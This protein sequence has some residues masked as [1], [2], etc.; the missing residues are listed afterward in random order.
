MVFAVALGTLGASSLCAQSI[1][2][3]RHEFVAPPNDAKPMVRW[4]WFGPAVTKEEIARE[5]QQMHEG[6]FGG[7]EL[8]SVY[9]LA[10]DDPQKGVRNLPYGSPEMVEM[11][12]Y[13]QQQGRALGMRAD[14]TLGSGWPF[15]G[16]HISIDQAA[17]KLKIVVAELPINKL[18]ELQEGDVPVAAF[19]ANGTREHYDAATARQIPFP[20]DGRLLSQKKSTEPQVALFFISSHT[21]QMV[22]RAAVGGEGFVLDHM[23]RAAIDTHLLTVGESLLRGFSDAPPY[24]I[25]SDSLEVYGSDWTRDLPEEFK[26]RR[27]YDLI[28]HLPELAEGGTEQAEAV[29]HDWAVTLSDLVRE[30]YLKPMADFA[31]AHGTRFRSQ[32]Y[33]T[34]AVTLSDERIPQLPEGEGPQW[35]SFSF[36][37][38]ASSANHLFG[39]NVTSAETWTWLHSP[40]FRATPLD[41]KAEADRMFLEGVNQ[42]IG[43]GWPYSPPYATEP[44]YSLYAAAVFNAH[45]PWWPVMP[46]VTR[47]LQRVSW[48]LRQGQP[49]NDVAV[50]LPEDDAQAD[51]RPGHVSV[52]DEM[53]VKITPT[54][55]HAIL[56]SGHNLDYVDGPAL[57]GL[58]GHSLLIVPPA[59][60]IRLQDLQQ[61]HAYVRGGGKVIF[62]GAVP[63]MAPGLTDAN[64]T[65]KIHALMTELQAGTVHVEGEEELSAAIERL[66]RPDLDVRSANGAVGFIRRHLPGAEIYFIANTSAETKTFPLRSS[67]GYSTAEWWNPESGSVTLAARDEPVALE[68]YG[69]RVLVLHKEAAPV[70]SRAVSLKEDG[71]PIVLSQWVEEFPGSAGSPP[72]PSQK[73]AS[74]IWTENSS[75]K[76][77]SG[78][79]RYETSFRLISS[80]AGEHIVLRFADGQALPN[81]QTRGKNGM[82]AWYDAPIREAAIVFINGERVG[83]LW[84]P[85]YELDVTQF[86]IAGENRIEIYV[87]NTAIN[88]LAG[89]TPRDYTALKAKY[90]DRFQM[91]DMDNLQPVPSGVFGPVRVVREVESH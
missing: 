51:F 19:V 64:D 29:R 74:T 42:I 79:V 24:A 21:R 17:G 70:I 67:S 56:S 66:I 31:A 26:K 10:L 9:P 45:N 55:M 46:D 81:T 14:L 83:S 8:A 72:L 3:V 30:N 20:K 90:G 73:N 43:H 36:T 40:V 68:P 27:G 57:K 49:A 22:K 91:Q 88:E 65:P 38:W 13:A 23:S 71:A 84:H 82:R 62:I 39:N 47:Y 60:R 61:I 32:T 4:W 89:Q 28:P 11:L 12:Q 37:R 75:T 52:T 33:G 1:D 41:M 18:P 76:F 5:I 58:A 34:P 53:K 25:F 86:V 77:Y 87:Y 7:F 2:Q 54:L 69:S 59:R 35:D 80:K 78:E 15:G 6:G 85:P 44:G 50:L 16:P 63:S 48:I